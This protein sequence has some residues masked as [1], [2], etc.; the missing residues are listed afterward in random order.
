MRD[1]RAKDAVNVALYA[2]AIGNHKV[3]SAATSVDSD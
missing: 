1:T 3:I 2:E